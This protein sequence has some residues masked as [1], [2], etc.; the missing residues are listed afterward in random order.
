MAPIVVA[1]ASFCLV[2]CGGSDEPDT[3]GN[4]DGP[5]GPTTVAVTGVSLNATTL[6]LTE[7]DSQTLVAAVSP[8][9][10]TN[11]KVNW[12]S[13]SSAVATVDGNGKVTGVKAGTATVTATSVDGGKTATCTVTVT[14]KNVAVTGVALEPTTATIVVG[15][16]VALKVKFTPAEPTNKKVTFKSSSESIATVDANGNVTGVKAGKTTIT[17]TTEDG[18]K[19]A[20]CE[21]TVTPKPVAVTGVKINVSVLNIEVGAQAIL[22][23]NISP[24]D[25][26]NKNVTWSS[27]DESVLTID[28]KGEVTGVKVGKATVTVTT[29]DGNKTATCEVNVKEATVTPTSVKIEPATLSVKV[30]ASEQLT[31]TVGP[32]G[33]PQDVSWSSS[34]TSIAT[35]DKTG[36]V[37]GVKAGTATITVKTQT[38]NKTATC[39]V[40]VTN[41]TVAVTGIKLNKSTTSLKVGG[42]ETLVATITPS[43]ATN[44]KVTWSTSAGS[45]ATVDQNGK[46]TA[47]KAGTASITAKT[48]DGG[49]TASCKVTVT[50]NTVAVTGVK[51]DKTTL[52]L[53]T[54]GT[55][56][57]N[58]TISPENA[59]NQKVTWSSSAST[60]AKVDQNG[61][62]TAVK[63]GTATITVKTDDQGKTASCKV[64]VKDGAVKVTKIEILNPSGT[65]ESF[66][67]QYITAD[68][69]TY[70]LKVKVYPENATNKNVTWKSSNTNAMT[71]SNTGLVRFLKESFNETVTATA[72]DGSGVS[73]SIMFSIN[74]STA[75]SITLTSSGG[76]ANFQTRPNGTFRV[77]A[78]LKGTGGRKVFKEEV[79]Y[80]LSSNAAGYAEITYPMSLTSCTIKGLKATTAS[81]P[82][83]LTATYKSLNGKVTK[84]VSQQIGIVGTPYISSISIT[85]GGSAQVGNSWPTTADVLPADADV[86]AVEWV[87]SDTS[88]V[89]LTY[90]DS[91]DKRRVRFNA[92][93]KGTSTIYC[94]ATDGSGVKS[95]SFVF[96]VY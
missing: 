20:K 18:N 86:K 87:S 50:T 80:S 96:Q 55:A 9:N 75:E 13:S 57:L 79:T 54:G 81:N 33:A 53:E 74:E 90:D 21:V 25:A 40:T 26:T 8:S 42:T 15:E 92:L 67:W 64:T 58:A 4:N 49:K 3:P 85:S 24:S 83:I 62:V 82:V 61:K 51:L 22:V 46:V 52:S 71:V 48:A 59:T 94:R 30:G 2:S 14:A 72:A 34:A 45:V 76:T 77:N 44:K 23:A 95:N 37:T 16:K 69:Y 68:D 5:A 31:A 84:T 43:D 36:K 56:T 89:K 38:G 1:M 32:E 47:V 17:V 11:T 7:G 63:A 29:E 70:Q 12:S 73:A 66:H 35:V 93:K 78:T 19:T 6:S 88:V 65:A 10:A 39:K 60:I 91:N 27:S 41:A 28:D